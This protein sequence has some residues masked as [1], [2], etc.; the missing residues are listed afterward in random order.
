M[1]QLCLC[2]DRAQVQLL[3]AGQQPFLLLL[4]PMVG[5]QAGRAGTVHSA[6]FFFQLLHRTEVR[7]LEGGSCARVLI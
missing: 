1:P 2:K 5:E 4:L 3:C 6:A 7:L